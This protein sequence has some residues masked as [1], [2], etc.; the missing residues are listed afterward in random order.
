MK[1]ADA[2]GIAFPE[3]LAKAAVRKYGKNKDHL[4]ME[5]CL[6]IVQRR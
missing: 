2:V 4:N 1:A 3:K 5:D 6:R